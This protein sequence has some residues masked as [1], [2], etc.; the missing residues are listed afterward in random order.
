MNK[1]RLLII[2]NI[3]MLFFSAFLVSIVFF[4]FL[5]TANNASSKTL[6]NNILDNDVLLKD[7]KQHKISVVDQKT[8]TLYPVLEKTRAAVVSISTKGKTS[9]NNNPFFNDPFF[10]NFFRFN[11]PQQQEIQSIGSGVIIN[12][13][14][15]LILT[16]YHV[17]KDADKIDVTLF[18][19]RK[20][21]AT[22]VGYDEKT[23]LA[24][25]QIQEE[26]FVQFDISKEIEINL[27]D[28]VLAIGNPF[29]LGH[30]VTYGIVSGINRSDIG[31]IKGNEKL[32][33]IDANINPGNSG[34]A[35]I[36]LEGR[37]IGINTAIL[38]KGGANVGIGF[39]IPIQTVNKIANQLIQ[40]GN[41]KRGQIG[42][43]AKTIEI[44]D[45]DRNSRGII[46]ESVLPD[47][48]AE[49]AGLLEGDIVVEIDNNTIN[50]VADF[51]YLID[52]NRVGE[53]IDVQ[54]LRNNLI[55]KFKVEIA[56][57]PIL[58]EELSYG[59]MPPVS[60]KS[61]QGATF[62][63]K[64]NGILVVSVEKGSNAYNI[65]LRKNDLIKQVNQKNVNDL[66]DLYDA[67]NDRPRGI[68][69]QLIRGNSSV[70]IIRN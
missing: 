70:L 14:N 66:N 35:L 28:Y 44:L 16:N 67:I 17:V 8:D 62:V 34:G 64:D 43:T 12:S 55:K 26:V 41:V 65:G 42:L 18:D 56:P 31:I 33:Q 7:D 29:G 21:E 5:N 25:L 24:I 68:V 1:T 11:L 30:T 36:N 20:S 32:I 37:L 49:K 38:S 6:K 54:I 45:N 57:F 3:V 9:I 48:S 19:E 4:D 52:L 39:A 60:I 47:S 23:D 59:E 10:E 53:T 40:Y 15:G 2:L 46:I 22:L 61:L 63:K 27:G 69:M 50:T 51:S 13:Q 58:E